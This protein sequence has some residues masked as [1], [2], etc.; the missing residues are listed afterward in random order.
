MTDE[1]I[2]KD[3]RMITFSFVVIVAVVILVDVIFF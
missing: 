2:G 1:E 3:I